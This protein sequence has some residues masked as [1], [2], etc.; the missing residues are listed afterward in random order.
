MVD[1][2]LLDP[3]EASL[4]REYASALNSLFIQL[5]KLEDFQTTAWDEEEG[6]G[7]AADEKKAVAD[8]LITQTWNYMR[9]VVEELLADFKR[10]GRASAGVAGGKSYDEI[11]AQFNALEY[12]CA[13]KLHT[14]RSTHIGLIAEIKETNRSYEVSDLLVSVSDAERGSHPTPPPSCSPPPPVYH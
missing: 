4:H 12:Y 7:Q 13:D 6:M 1:D 10:T 8:Q 3:N 2:N 11:M 9:D 14:L 5:R